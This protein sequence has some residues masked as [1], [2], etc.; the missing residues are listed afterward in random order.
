M[1]YSYKPMLA[2]EAPNAFSDK[3]WI[4]E[5]K[6]D[7]FR[8]LAY[9]NGKVSLRSRNNKELI[10]NFPELKELKQLTRNVVLD[11]EIIIIKNGKADFQALQERG[12]A[13]K[14]RDIQ[15]ERIASPAEYIVFDILEKDGNPLTN[16]SLIERKKILQNSLREGEH[17]TISD[18][19]E[20]KGEDYYKAALEKG[21]EGI[22][23]KRK[24][25]SYQSGFRSSDWLKMKK[26]QSCDCVI[27]GYT[28]GT[29]VRA[30]TFGAL[31]LGLYDK[32][33]PVFVGK[34]GT[35]F[36]DELLENLSSTFQKLKTEKA[37]FKTELSDEIT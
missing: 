13:V 3:D 36:S 32:E 1:S 5:I 30:Q 16:L 35:G 17:V 11:G 4:F 28:R 27:F 15:T 24:D 19:I 2:K 31:I 37:P 14:A 7:G 33:N 9:V 20:E 12:K 6:W 21:I 34:V 26:L 29:G 18:F 25:S 22:I 10:D 8:A 23:A